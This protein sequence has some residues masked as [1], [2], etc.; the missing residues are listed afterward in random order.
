MYRTGPITVLGSGVAASA[1]CLSKNA[2]ASAAIAIK[3]NKYRIIEFLIA[4]MHSSCGFG[5]WGSKREAR[6]VFPSR[7]GWASR[8]PVIASRDRELRKIVLARCQDRRARR[9]PYPRETD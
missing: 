3:V 7:V 8:P 6:A 1:F 2:A 9:P 4:R 5:S